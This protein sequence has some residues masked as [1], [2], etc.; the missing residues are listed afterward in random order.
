MKS[1]KEFLNEFGPMGGTPERDRRGSSS[2]NRT[3]R[4]SGQ[5]KRSNKSDSTKVSFIDVDEYITNAE[6][7]AVK[8]NVDIEWGEKL[9][10]G[11]IELFIYGPKKARIDFL[12]SMGWNRSD[13]R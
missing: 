6:A 8:H 7:S 9:P 5:S 11:E 3:L 2:R 10:G 13:I 4:S 1:F 12:V